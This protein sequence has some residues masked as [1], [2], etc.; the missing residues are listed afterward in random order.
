MKTALLLLISAT[1]MFAGPCLDYG[2]LKNRDHIE[3]G[4][5]IDTNNPTVVKAATEA[6]NFWAG[7]IDLSWHRVYDDSC[8]IEF[9]PHAWQAGSSFRT[10]GGTKLPWKASFNGVVFFQYLQTNYDLAACFKHE[11]GHMLG[12]EHNLA[13]DSLMYPDISKSMLELT[14]DDK[15]H[16]RKFH[17]LRQD[18]DK[19]ASQPL[20]LNKAF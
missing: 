10:V 19:L 5:R 14:W 15:R 2:K 3:I 7:V 8:A 13:Q 18:A 6:L 12:L 11:M 9:Q 16:L 17:T 20:S 4:V 1:A